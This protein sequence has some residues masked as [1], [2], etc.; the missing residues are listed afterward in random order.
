[1]FS[2]T[3]IEAGKDFNLSSPALADTFSTIAAQRDT[4]TLITK[5]SSLPWTILFAFLSAVFAFL[6]WW[7]AKRSADA[8][9]RSARAA[10]RAYETQF[11]VLVRVKV[12]MLLGGVGV[13]NFTNVG[14]AV[15]VEEYGVSG[16]TDEERSF[17]WFPLSRDEPVFTL[18]R[19]QTEEVSFSPNFLE[20]MIYPAFG[21]NRPIR[22]KAYVVLKSG[23]RFVSTDSSITL[24]PPHEP[25]SRPKVRPPDI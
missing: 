1:V 24:Y 18:E 7:Q 8:A 25:G 3:C 12:D 22:L 11:G 21:R 6:G 20:E 2:T 13:V 16:E 19:L 9:G 15:Q 23:E 4:I 17:T 14:H 5:D 10:E